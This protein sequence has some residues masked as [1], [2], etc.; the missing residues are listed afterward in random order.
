MTLENGSRI[1][2]LPGSE[3]TIRGFSGATLL[4]LDE[5]SRI[6]DPLY[7]SVRPMLAVSGGRLVALSTPF[8]KRGWFHGAWEEG[9]P[10]WERVKITAYDC[11]R[12]SPVWL[13]QERQQIGECGFAKSI[14]ANLSTNSRRCLPVR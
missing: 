11:P 6:E 2:A 7:Y 1:V 12:I 5:A 13:E 9:G 8:G 14:C 4:I 10:G 3:Q